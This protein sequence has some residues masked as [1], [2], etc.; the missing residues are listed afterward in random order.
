MQDMHYPEAICR[1]CTK[2]AGYAE[3]MR[4][5]YPPCFVVLLDAL[6]HRHFLAVGKQWHPLLQKP[7]ELGWDDW[8]VVRHQKAM[9]HLQCLD[10][11]WGCRGQVGEEGD[12]DW[13]MRGEYNA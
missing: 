12:G 10:A 9:W 3:N 4:S 2:Y 13:G 5:A 1:I 7:Q 11:C 6:L 8:E